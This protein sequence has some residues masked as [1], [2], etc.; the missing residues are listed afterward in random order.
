[1]DPSTLTGRRVHI[2]V[3][4]AHHESPAAAATHLGFE[5]YAA[6]VLRAVVEDHVYS[7]VED[8]ILGIESSSYEHGVT[9]GRIVY[10]RQVG[11]S[12]FFLRIP[13]ELVSERSRPTQTSGFQLPNRG[14]FF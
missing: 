3:V 10:R 6:A 1:M 12:G 9:V 8:Q 2:D 5:I 4:V 7:V 14:V 11:I 13:A